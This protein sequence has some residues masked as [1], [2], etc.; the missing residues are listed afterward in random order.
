MPFQ[1]KKYLDGIGVPF[2]ENNKNS[3]NCLLD[4][5]DNNNIVDEKRDN[6][7]QALY[8]NKESINK[9]LYESEQ[10]ITINDNLTKLS[11]LFYLD[12]L[13]MSDPNILNYKFSF[14]FIQTLF[15]NIDKINDKQTK[16]M[17]CKIIIDLIQSYKGFGNY[18]K[19]EEEEKSLKEMNNYCKKEILEQIDNNKKKLESYDY[20]IEQS[21][22]ILYMDVFIKLI[23]E[24]NV[25]FDEVYNIL[26]N[27]DLEEINI[28]ENMFNKFNEFI[29]S[30]RSISNK[31]FINEIEDLIINKINFYYIIFKYFLKNQIFIEQ[32]EFLFK[33]KEIYNRFNQQ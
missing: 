29:E 18:D 9:F 1:L 26:N 19:I 32:F 5:K 10:S 17:M 6:F 2:L 30:L 20:I 24:D 8:F 14:E 15:G 13:I 21:I 4:Y 7:L 33:Y 25:D 11:K 27:L 31:F 3:I 12:L 16:I 22:D 23:K 28:T